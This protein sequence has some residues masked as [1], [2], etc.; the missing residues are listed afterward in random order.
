MRFFV[1]VEYPN[2]CSDLFYVDADLFKTLVADKGFTCAA[3]IRPNY[4][5]ETDEGEKI[6]G[7]VSLSPLSTEKEIEEAFTLTNDC[8]VTSEKQELY[9]RVY[10]K[11]RMS[12][13]AGTATE[14]AE[15]VLK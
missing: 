10:E 5:Y 3:V 9:N 7:T 12:L 11:A 1:Y 6:S 15:E 4:S 8:S 2:N 13:S 14:I